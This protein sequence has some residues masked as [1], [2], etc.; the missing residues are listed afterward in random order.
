MNDEPI[1]HSSR[2]TDADTDGGKRDVEADEDKEGVSEVTTS[3]SS[4]PTA[5]QH[6]IQRAS[7]KSATSAAS[8][9]PKK[10]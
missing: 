8:T 6:G 2:V 1:H 10:T 3:G 9:N 7:A 4:W 5:A